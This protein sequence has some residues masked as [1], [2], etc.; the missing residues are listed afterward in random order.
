M[1]A[2]NEESAEFAGTQR[3]MMAMTLIAD[4]KV[5][6]RCID[7]YRASAR[8]HGL[9]PTPDH[10]VLGY[11][12]LI[13]DTDEEA[14]H[15]LGEGQRYFHRILMHPIRD[16]QR[17][18]I[19]KSRFFGE[20]H[21]EHGA[22]FV[23]RLSMLKERNIEEMIEAGSVLCGSPDTVLKQIKRVNA[24]LGNGHFIINMQI[25][26]IPDAVVRRGMELFRDRVLPEARGL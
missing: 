23:N 7:A 24:E 11:N 2:S 19:Q 13:A 21:G 16:A 6:R 3:A 8:A 22:G 18:V 20:S 10:I 14:R 4:L 25:G 5:A 26:N 17:L 1:S 15:Y 12:S 9:E